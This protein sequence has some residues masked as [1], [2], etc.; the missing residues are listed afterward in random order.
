MVEWLWGRLAIKRHEF[1]SWDRILDFSKPE[2][3]AYCAFVK[4]FDIGAPSAS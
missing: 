4:S 3:T 1:E 2:R